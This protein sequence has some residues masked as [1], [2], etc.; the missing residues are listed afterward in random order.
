MADRF[1]VYAEDCGGSGATMGMVAGVGGEWW[2]TGVL[3]DLLPRN[4][5]DK[6]MNFIGNLNGVEK[7]LHLPQ[8]LQLSCPQQDLDQVGL[9]G[10]ELGNYAYDEYNHDIYSSITTHEDSSIVSIDSCFQTMLPSDTRML[11]YVDDYTQEVLHEDNTSQ[12]VEEIEEISDIELD[13][14]LRLW[15]DIEEMDDLPKDF[16]LENEG[17]CGDPF[18]ESTDIPMVLQ[19]EEVNAKGHKSLCSLL[20]AYGEA[21]EMGHRELAN[22]LVRCVNEKVSP[23][24]GTMERVAFS[25]FHSKNQIEYIKH[26]SMKNFKLAFKVFYETFPY[27]R[28]CHFVANSAIVDAV[29]SYSGKLHIIDFDMGEGVQWPS[30]LEAIGKLKRELKLTSIRTNDHNYCFEETR[31]RL[32]DYANNCGLTL[33]VQDIRIE[34]LAWEIERSREHELLAFNCMVTLPHMGRTRNR[35]EVLHFVRTAK[36]LLSVKKGIITFGDGEDLERMNDRRDFSSFFD[37]YIRHYY[38]LCQSMEIRTLEN[39]KEARIAME[40]LFVWPLVSPFSCHQKWVNA[41]GDFEFKENIGLM[42]WRLSKESLME[43]KEMVKMLQSSY[44]VKVE[45]KYNNEMVLLWRG[46]SLVRVYAWK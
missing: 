27:G 21:I 39:L 38:A 1:I 5:Q 29:K 6:K 31:N 16:S 37:D 44:N 11:C 3:S 20:K 19:P 35:V 41:R 22:V 45:G 24:G 36:K 33:E 13:D 15:A 32:L 26:E 25:M 18:E 17:V 43:V 42:G 34:D 23:L 8:V 14:V 30:M 2:S 12:H 4:F 10:L 40:S 46:T 28:F 7:K 9:Y